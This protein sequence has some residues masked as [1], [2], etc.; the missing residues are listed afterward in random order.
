[1]TIKNDKVKVYNE[2]NILQYKD[3]KRIDKICNSVKYELI[4]GL[5]YVKT[6]M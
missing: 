2:R 1:M 6:L 4:Y 5:D 3:M